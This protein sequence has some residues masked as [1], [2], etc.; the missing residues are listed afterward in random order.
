LADESQAQRSSCCHDLSDNTLERGRES[1]RTN[2]AQSIAS[3]LEQDGLTLISDVK[4]AYTEYALA[5]ER[6]ALTE[7]A[8]CP[9]RPFESRIKVTITP[10]RTGTGINA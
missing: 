6:I 3:G 7:L 10:P 2:E 1:R 5:Q 4:L 8:H 9:V